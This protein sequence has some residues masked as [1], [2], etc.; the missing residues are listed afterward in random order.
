MAEN[1]TTAGSS[2]ATKILKYWLPVLFMIGVMYYASTDVFSGDNTRGIIERIVL[3]LRPHTSARGLM[4]IN[5]I[6]RKMAHFAEYA[7]LAGL[8]FRAFR[9]DS[10]LRWRVRWALYSFALAASWA[11]LDE[12]HQSFTRTRGGS[13]YDSLL[14]S[15]GALFMLVMIALLTHRKSLRP[16]NANLFKKP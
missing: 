6:V 4:K 14:D 5:Y 2:L 8:L 10:I 15:A 1:I 9:A 11:L 16:N 12:L 7:I 3:W 13:I